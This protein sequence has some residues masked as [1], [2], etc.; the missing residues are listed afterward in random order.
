ML[1]FEDDLM[2]H[3][4]TTAILLSSKNIVLTHHSFVKLIINLTALKFNF[5][6]EFEVFVPRLISHMIFFIQSTFT[7]Y[8]SIN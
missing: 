7:L 3:S 2:N 5:M 6:L 1:R 4:V 8:V